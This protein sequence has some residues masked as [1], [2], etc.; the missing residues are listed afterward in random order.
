MTET[1]EPGARWRMPDW[2]PSTLAYL[3]AVGLGMVAVVPIV[4]N[5]VRV[6]D[7]DPVYMRNLVER[8]AELGGSYYENGIHNR[9]PLEPLVYDLAGRLAPYAAFWFVI[10]A[11]VALCAAL[12]AWTAARTARFVGANHS[13]AV[14][15][16]AA[17]YVFFTMADVGYAGVLFLR[18]ITTA[19]LAPVWLL[20]LSERPWASPRAARWS[21]IAAGALL[22]FMAQQLLTTAFSGAVVGL[23]ALALLRV[24]RPTEVAGHL[25]AAAI[26]AVVG[27]A[28]TPLWY[29][30][31]GSF[32]EYWSGWWTYARFMSD[33]PGRSFG[34]QL[35][36]G[37]DRFYEFHSRN[38]VVVVLLVGFAALT[39]AL[40][41]ELSRPVRIVHVGLL[42]WFAAGWWELVLS[43]RYSSHYYVVVAV[44]TACMGAAVAGH[45]A[46][47]VASRRPATRIS[48][49]VPALAA[50]LAIFLTD[51]SRFA[52]SVTETREFRGVGRWF[53]EREDQLGGGDRSTRAV[54]DLVSHDQDGLLAWTNDP[55]V[56]MKNHRIPATRFQWKSFMLGEI[57]LGR[58]S[59]DYVLP[60]TWRWFREDLAETDPVAF[61]E[62]ESFDAGTP[63]D[64]LIHSR[65]T[66]VYPGTPT[67]LWL[68]NDVAA[69]LLGP[70]ASEPWV[71]P[72]PAAV[73]QGWTVDGTTA[74]F[75]LAPGSAPGQSL[76]VGDARCFRLEGVADVG[77]PGV[78]ADLKI[79]FT[80]P[81][82]PTAEPQLLTL[83]GARAGSGSEGLGPLGFEALDV[84]LD[85]D[86]PVRLAVVVGTRSAGL[87]VNGQLRAA[88]RLREGLTLASLESAS[89]DLT[90]ADL[91]V[92]DG[93]AG[94]GC[95]SG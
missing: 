13:V 38:P 30:A 86:G 58:T 82:D 29:L 77:L 67:K 11:L 65:F 61:A 39:W 63:F 69:D 9:G 24:R 27:F 56:Y 59:L 47:A 49:L 18:N 20:A 17:T 87:V 60:Q 76:V 72:R 31:R 81:D 3:T 88:V 70:G 23:V 62:T 26:A 92:G 93:P 85:G 44:P 22:G 19:L 5:A 78:L 91:R 53:D 7:V 8:T 89:P 37:W 94:G 36:L 4:G 80:D 90:L 33:G 43:Q 84:A 2:V 75:S 40:W 64:E 32:A 74:R 34:S 54:L 52:D 73:G 21:S 35:G 41:R 10:S 45:L 79:R 51:A 15:V 42:A 1:D 57:Y 55:F 46:R 25:L 50:V 71:S 48:L 66:E 14:G 6:Q 12:L 95:P 83:E 16:A 28:V 68:R